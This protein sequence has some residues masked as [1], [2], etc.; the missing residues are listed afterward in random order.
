[1]AG[2]C[3]TARHLYPYCGQVTGYLIHRH[4]LVEF[5]L[6]PNRSQPAVANLNLLQY[7]VIRLFQS[8]LM[9]RDEKMI[10]KKIED[11]G[12]GPHHETQRRARPDRVHLLRQNRNIDAKRHVLQEVFHRRN[13]LRRLRL[14]KHTTYKN[15]PNG[16]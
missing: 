2:C 10:E 16:R 12:Q 9:N 3:G 13:L 14:V 1:M 5:L 15:G 8:I 7:D 4:C 6:V 11:A